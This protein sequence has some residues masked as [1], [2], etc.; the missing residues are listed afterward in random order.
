MKKTST[1]G[2]LFVCMGNICRS[3]TAE[4]VFR[5]RLET[6]GLGDTIES[7]SAGTHSYHIGAPPDRRAQAA[8]ARRGIDISDL[9]AR[10]V[11][12]EDFARFELVVAMDRDN[13]MELEA[14]CPPE[15]RERLVLMMDYAANRHETEVPD[16]YYGGSNG[17]EQVLDLLEDAV[18]GLLQQI[19][20]GP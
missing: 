20:H 15:L 18:D 10:R 7:D 11:N 4:G 12:E 19:R 6:A 16:P 5:K 14:L 8:A 1:I 13:L 3:P 17:F 9:R 2:V